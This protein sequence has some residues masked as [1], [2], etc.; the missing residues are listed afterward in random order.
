MKHE[1]ENPAWCEGRV[2]KSERSLLFSALMSWFCF[3]TN[4]HCSMRDSCAIANAKG[5]LR[6]QQRGCLVKQN[7]TLA[8]RGREQQSH[9]L[10]TWQ[11]QSIVARG[12]IVQD[13]TNDFSRHHCLIPLHPG[14]P[15]PRSQTQLHFCRV[16]NASCAPQCRCTAWR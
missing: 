12:K 13:N 16:A 6:S 1:I 7:T 15:L 5:L 4:S 8:A 14:S 11:I 3:L 10:A 2:Q 9:Q